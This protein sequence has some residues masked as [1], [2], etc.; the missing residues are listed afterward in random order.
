MVLAMSTGALRTL[1]LRYDSKAEPL[2]ASVPVVDFSP[3]RML[4][5]RFTGMLVALPADSDDP[6]QRVRVCHENAVRAGRATSFW[7]RV[8]Q[9]LGGY[10]PPAGGS[11]CSGRCLSDGRNKVLSEYLEYPVRERG[12][13]WG[14]AGHRDLFGGP[15]VDRQ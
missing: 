1:L 2:L 11:P 9:P 6:L 5:S 7:D 14:R 8:D 4:G 12:Y 10:W 15:V 3:E 13:A